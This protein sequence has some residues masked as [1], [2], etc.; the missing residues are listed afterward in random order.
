METTSGIKLFSFSSPD[1]APENSIPLFLREEDK[2]ISFGTYFNSFSIDAYKKYTDIN[3]IQLCMT[4]KESGTV[5]LI[6][7]YIK[8]NK[9][10]KE[11]LD[12][13]KINKNSQVSFNVNLEKLKGGLL[14]PVYISDN[15]SDKKNYEEIIDNA[16]WYCTSEKVK[17]DSVKLAAVICTFKRENFV[18]KNAEKLSKLKILNQKKMSVFII[19]NGNTINS[20]LINN[21]QIK[22]IPNKNLGGSGGFTRG[23]IEVHKLNHTLSKDNKFSH[24]I[25]MDDDINFMPELFEKISSFLSLLKTEYKDNAIGGAMLNLNSPC[26]QYENGAKYNF[27][28]ISSFGNSLDLS[29]EKNIILNTREKKA[30]FNAWWFCCYPLSKLDENN[31][32][33]PF[34]IKLDDIEYGIR[35]FKNKFIFLNG[36]SVWHQEFTGKD[37]PYL[38]YYLI[39]N[40]LITNAM[41]CRKLLIIKTV[42]VFVMHLTLK[43]LKK[44]KAFPFLMKAFRDFLQGPDFILNTDGEK[45]NTQLRQLNEFYKQ[46]KQSFIYIKLPLILPCSCIKILFHAKT[47]K[48]YKKD[49]P[50]GYSLTAW[51]KRLGM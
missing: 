34:F 29:S 3:Q 20:E 43:A 50:A 11:V 23:M 7:S 13:K 18:Y 28:T 6:H 16:A 9:L 49:L 41:F 5:E 42:T 38:H 25:L 40:R 46:K 2:E 45:L 24:I 14:Y 37:S 31:L 15:K 30:D 21:E 12:I 17:P 8:R 47:I 51:K 33:V 10:K 22:I 27:L 39:R 35:N 4:L 36:I 32:P 48:A 1:N 26:I 44:R 19:D